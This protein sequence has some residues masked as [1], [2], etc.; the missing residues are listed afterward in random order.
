MKKIIGLLVMVVSF[1]AISVSVDAANNVAKV[2][3]KEYPTVQEAITNGNG[4]EVILLANVTENIVI[5]NGTTLT[6]NLNGFNMTN[7]ALKHTIINHG[8]VVIV[9][10]GTVDNVSHGKAALYNGVDGIIEVQ[11]GTYTRSLESG[12][13]DNNS[14]GNSYYTIE[15]HGNM[16]LSNIKVVNNGHF[17]SMIHNGFYNGAKENPNH[18]YNPTLTIYS[19]M[20]DGGLNTVKNDDDSTLVIKGGTFTNT[21]QAAILN[22]NKTTINGGTFQSAKDV[23]LNGKSDNGRNAGLLTITDGN[24]KA[25][26]GNIIATM[27]GSIAFEAKDVQVSGGTYNKKVDESYLALNENQELV[28]NEDGSF[29]IKTEMPK[30]TPTPTPTPDTTIN[31]NPNT[32]DTV[33]SYIGLALLGLGTLLISAK[34]VLN[35]TC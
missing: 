32:N 35:P 5:P 23:I 25:G 2:A 31:Q 22:W 20:F 6:L 16:I 21:T 1:F 8:N 29:T 7:V 30:P 18:E 34:K 24:F 3:D 26:S 13:N 17:S 11:G 33:M 15:N 9:G 28:Q 4:G 27:N 12:V 14:G 19:G 10:E